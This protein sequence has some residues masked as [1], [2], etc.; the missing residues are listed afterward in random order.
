MHLI[1]I[2][3][4]KTC[5][6][7]SMQSS[8]VFMTIVYYFGSYKL[9]TGFYLKRLISIF[10]VFNVENRLLF[11]RAMTN[12]ALPP[13]LLLTHTRVA[14]QVSKVKSNTGKILPNRDWLLRACRNKRNSFNHITGRTVSM[15]SVQIL[16]F[17]ENAWRCAKCLLRCVRK[18]LRTLCALRQLLLSFSGVWGT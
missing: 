17:L 16:I 18:T 7:R 14:S 5:W 3:I 6:P 10:L 1:N 8:P 9:W 13:L 2:F 4:L 11:S 15:W 12:T